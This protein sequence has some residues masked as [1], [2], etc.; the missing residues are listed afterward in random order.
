MR[1]IDTTVSR[2]FG[3][4]TVHFIGEDDEHVEVTLHDTG[5]QCGEDQLIARAKAAMIQLT[6][7]GTRD[8]GGS[9]NTYDAL[10]NGNLDG[11]EPLMHEPSPASPDDPGPRQ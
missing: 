7:F 9:V 10:S 1:H 8:G 11:G 4:V 5:Q 3:M 2:L 6:A